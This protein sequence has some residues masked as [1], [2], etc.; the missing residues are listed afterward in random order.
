MKKL[1]FTVYENQ[2][3][4][5]T[6]KSKNKSKNFFRSVD[7]MS[8]KRLASRVQRTAQSGLGNIFA[9]GQTELISFAAGLPD[10]GSFPKA[11]LKQAFDQVFDN[12]N[13]ETLQ[14]HDSLGLLPLRE[15]L[16]D[17]LTKQG[18][19][20]KTAELMLTQGAQQGIDLVARLVLNKGDGLVVEAP[21]Y[22]GA[23]ANFDAYE[24]TY[25]EVN[26]E[27]D[28]M[29]ITQ[30]QKVLLQ[31]DV[32]LVYTIPDYQNPTGAV[33]S[34]AKR[35]AL[36]ELANRYNFIIL[37]DS[38]YRELCY[39]GH[40]L[41]TLRSMDTEGRVISL[42]SFSKILAPG[43]RLGWL[44]ADAELFQDI[45]ALKAG[46]DV[47]TPNLIMQGVNTYLDT[48]N[49]DAHIQ[50]I[51]KV[52]QE[53][54][55]FML[56][57][58]QRELPAGVTYTKPT[59]G[60]F[61]W[62]TVPD[63]IDLGQLLTDRMLPEGHVSYVP[64]KNLYPSKAVHNQARLNF[65]NPSLADIQTGIHRLSEILADTIASKRPSYAFSNK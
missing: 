5:I 31:H 19:P 34:L 45:V 29:N 47:E 22:I 26:M 44:N 36:L 61:I 3:I 49:L 21:T 9:N 41:P 24:P 23:L 39:N 4:I 13:G 7:N 8:K 51:N 38:P 40:L 6:K 50:S 53:K 59:G 65:T 62:L 14:Y 15:K 32:K 12:D 58:L 48:N 11:A 57:C 42:G 16:A 33:M 55:T 56:Q 43:L 60:F 1:N 25:H 46:L 10:T 64:A 52:Y 54:M 30:L 2:Y 17:R 35:Q 18:T 28:G 20:T 37:E 63:N 27:P